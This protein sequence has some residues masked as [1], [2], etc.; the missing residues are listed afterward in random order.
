MVTVLAGIYEP[1][2]MES[3]EPSAKGTG[4]RVACWSQAS[5]P[6]ARIEYSIVWATLPPA[7]RPISTVTGRARPGM[8]TARLITEPLLLS[9]STG[10]AVSSLM[11]K[12]RP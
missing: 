8:C 3:R 5:A 4:R 9:S 6:T 7:P 1:I 10:Q 11:C 2:P 12:Q